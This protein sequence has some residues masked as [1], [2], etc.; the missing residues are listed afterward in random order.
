[1]KS[2]SIVNFSDYWNRPRPWQFGEIIAE[3]YWKKDKSGYI[4]ESTPTTSEI[5]D[6]M[7]FPFYIHF[8]HETEIFLEDFPTGLQVETLKGPNNTN[9]ERIVFKPCRIGTASEKL[10]KYAMDKN[11]KKHRI[12]ND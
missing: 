11:F 4:Q 10:L 3:S 8:E 1:M 7:F 6:Q 9:I 5:L 2:K 12:A